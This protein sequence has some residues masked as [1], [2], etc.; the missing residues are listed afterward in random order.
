MVAIAAPAEIEHRRNQDQSARGDALLIEL[1][2]KLRRAEA[3]IAFARDELL[4]CLAPIF[5]DP[6]AHEGRKHIDIAID[7]PELL[8]HLVAGR[9]EAAVAGA[10]R[11]DEHE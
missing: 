2:C 11:I 9:D 6:S 5:L 3:A 10:D 8:A 4:R 7:R 1:R